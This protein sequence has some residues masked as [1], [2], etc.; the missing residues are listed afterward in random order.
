MKPSSSI[1]RLGNQVIIYGA[2]L[3][4]IGLLGYLSNPAAAKT[5]LISGGTFGSINIL[6]GIGL[7]YGVLQLRFVA[8]GLAA[9]LSLIFTWRSTVSWLAVIQGEPK[10]IAAILITSM[11]GASIV[12]IVKLL[13]HKG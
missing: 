3:C 12:I 10:L 4:L 2:F 11:L 5:A 1:T 9:L 7:R 8:L 6:L 13:R